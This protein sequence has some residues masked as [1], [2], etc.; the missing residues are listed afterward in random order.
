MQSI[1]LKNAQEEEKVMESEYDNYDLQL[2]ELNKNII[3]VCI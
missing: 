2:S 1:S 3:I